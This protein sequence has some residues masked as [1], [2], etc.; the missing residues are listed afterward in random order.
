MS[1]AELVKGGYG[2]DE[3]VE[4][5]KM[6][7]GK[8]DII[9]GLRRRARGPGGVRRDASVHVH[10]ARLQRLSGR[11]DQKARENAGRHTWRT[12]RSGR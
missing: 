3:G 2:L 7:D 9:H 6:I 11:G 1:G 4:M 10:R 5:A 12:E 8:V